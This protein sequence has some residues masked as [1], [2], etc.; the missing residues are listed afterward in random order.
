MG[1]ILTNKN[2]VQKE[3]KSRFIQGILAIIQCRI[4]YCLPVCYP[5]IKS[6]RYTEP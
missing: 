5:K 2:S 6:L 3:I 1:T 4:F